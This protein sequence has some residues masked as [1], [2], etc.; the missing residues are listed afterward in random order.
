[1]SETIKAPWTQEQVDALNAYQ[2]DGWMHPYTCC[3]PDG[4]RDRLGVDGDDRELVATKDGW[5]CRTCDYTQ[6]WAHAFSAQPN[7]FA[8]PTPINGGKNHH[9]D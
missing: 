7:P 9:A 8:T 3:G 6:D 2:R 4:C 5:V 1:M